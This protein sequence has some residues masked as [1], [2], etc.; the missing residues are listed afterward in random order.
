MNSIWDIFADTANKNA[1]RIAVADKFSSYTYSELFKKAKSYG[2]LLNELSGKPIVVFV[3]RSAESV[4]QLLGVVASGNY[5]IPL[6][7]CLPASKLNLIF[8]DAR[9]VA[10]LGTED[11]RQI[12]L[13]L[14]FNCRFFTENDTGEPMEAAKAVGG[15]EPLYM[16]YTSGSTGKPKGVLKSH[17]AM[18]SFIQAFTE[19]FPFEPD[20]VVGNQTPLF[21]DASAKDLY[22]TLK[23]GATMEIIPSELFIF[24]LSLINYLNDRHII[25]ICWVP[26]A[27]CII[28]QLSTFEE[29]LPKYLKN[30]FFVGEMFPIKQLNKWLASLP[31]ARFVNLYGSSEMAGV[32]C[33][34]RIKGGH[35]D[36][37]TL[38]MG[39]PMPNCNITLQNDT[40]TVTV[41]NEVGELI[42]SS[43]ALALC[44]Y[45][46]RDHTNET[47]FM[48]NGQRC[49]R[50]G[51]LGKYDENGNIC[52]VS[53]K[54]FQIKHMGR[55][56]ELGE[57]ESACDK[58]TAIE[59]CC[60]IYDTSKKRIT[61]FC[62]LC[63]GS[64]TE[65]QI[66]EALK[67]I[68]PDYMVPGKIKILGTIPLN[69]NGKIDR[70]ALN[71]ALA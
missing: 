26:S 71:S 7:P 48:Q 21:F 57:I 64:V 54:D 5:Y 68:L 36:L 52:F 35:L 24:P 29:V 6:D 49:L 67:E 33:Y 69:H 22:L 34:Y 60:C 14:K 62:Q 47:F 61:L 4:A 8:E 2:A 17:G 53:R 11:D 25:W 70:Q 66:R 42:I 58:L 39:K 44:Y 46:D 32:C 10:V 65:K 12:I 3:G 15:D 13:N 28:T 23:T 37:D 51:D 59:K 20:T 19:E 43:P 31:D 55:R 41:A 9:P 16:I 1:E 40:G 38:P 56:I 27:L 50:S 18:C 45:N 30:V 63:D